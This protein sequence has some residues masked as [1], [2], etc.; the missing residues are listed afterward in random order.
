[1]IFIAEAD[2]AVLMSIAKPI[3]LVATFAVWAWFISARVDKWLEHYY[4]PREMWNGMLLGAGGLGLLLALLVP[5]FWIGWPLA[6]LVLAGSVLGYIAFHNQHVGP[7]GKIDL[8][9]LFEQDEGKKTSKQQAAARVLLLQPN[10]EALPVPAPDSEQSTAHQ[11]LEDMLEYA[12]PRRA[13]RLDIVVKANR[14]GALVQ[15]D[16][17]RYL[18]PSINPAEG[19]QLVQYLKQHAGMDLEDMRRKQTGELHFA[20]QNEEPQSAT[21]T[22]AGSTQELTLG[23]ALNPD[24]A[25]I[26]S[27]SDLGLLDV[28][29]KR[30]AALFEDHSGVV[31][32]SA[33]RHQGQTTTLYSLVAEHDPYT[34]SIVTLEQE[35]TLEL[36]GVT[37]NLLES[38]ITDEDAAKR[39][40]AII[41]QDPGVI[42]LDR[43]TGPKMVEQIMMSSNDIRY[44]IGMREETTLAALKAWLKV[45]GTTNAGTVLRAITAQRLVRRVCPTCRVG[46]RPDE[47]VLRKLNLPVD[48]VGQ[49]YKSSGKVQVAKEVQ[50]CPDC[51]GL[52]YRGRAAVF[53]VM[54]LDDTARELIASDDSEQL[55]AHLRKNKLLYLQ[56]AGVFKVADGT[57][58]ISE[59][60]RAMGKESEKPIAVRREDYGRPDDRR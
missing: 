2:T 58:T 14:A 47:G 11:H 23:M 25:V 33:A 29:R 45:A 52:G 17:V 18:L 32:A 40:A 55:R 35:V 48:S 7:E 19:R 37:H 6:I 56:E 34:M 57:T 12:L 38:S 42:L 22:A 53:E 49:F 1:M 59:L 21:V 46:Y 24:T 4:L 3:L 54:V 43:V 9:K 50:P 27:F 51:V 31:L 36:E 8:K 26:K 5:I 10:G 39:L 30:L 41:R 13:E 28:Q 20:K 16:G 15:V 44:Y 60:T